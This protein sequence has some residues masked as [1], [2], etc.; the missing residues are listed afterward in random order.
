MFH[1]T[2]FHTEFADMF[3]IYIYTRPHM[4]SSNDTLKG[5]NNQSSKYIFHAATILP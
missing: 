1:I 3:T 5:T 4:H 2:V